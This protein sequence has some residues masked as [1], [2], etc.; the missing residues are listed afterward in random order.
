MKRQKRIL[1][2]F[3]T[4]FGIVFAVLL[5]GLAVVTALLPDQDYS[6]TEKRSLAKRP[7]FT[8]NS[9]ADGSFMDGIEE[10]EADQFPFRAELMRARTQIGIW[11]GEIRS[12]N[13]YRCPD[14]RLMESF[15]MP[16]D[17]AMSRQTDAIIEFAG[18]YPDKKMY[19]CL[20][21][22]AVSVLEEE[23]PAAAV[24][25]D[26]DL[27]LDR[28]AEALGSV[29]TVADVRENLRANRNQTELYYHTDHHWTTDAAFLA[30]QELALAMELN[31]TSA[32]TPGVV[33][34][35][36]SGSLI[37]ASGFPAGQYDAVSVYVPEEEPVYTVTYDNERRMTASVY[38]PE[39]LDSDDP[40][41]IF[42]GGN[43]AKI[44]IRTAAD[45]D[46]KLLIF[47]DSYANCLIPFLIPDFSQIT[48]IDA[49]YYYD[50]L[51]I[52]MQSGGYTDVLF[53]YNVN[54]LS[55]DSSLA[56]VLGNEQ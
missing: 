43:Y 14:G 29:G 12:Q 1:R 55:K 19:F 50:D 18:R 42:L 35:T 23:L 46:R 10:W 40:Y 27:Y 2:K 47:K 37:S 21:P 49:R 30:W 53:L 25:D 7:A 17:E 5:F 41:R 44:T 31:N 13:I 45:T 38:C 33:C 28:M 8:L 51:D 56:P 20:V 9:V 26:Q 16:S 6:E 34:N 22:N 11:L 3:Y 54:T 15:S 39:Y 4:A 52:E 36:F 24:T 32:Y 48:V